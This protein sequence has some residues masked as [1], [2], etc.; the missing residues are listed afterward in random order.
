MRR[1]WEKRVDKR[2]QGRE[3]KEGV[4]LRKK[5]DLEVC[6]VW[7]IR[8]VSLRY[9][10]STFVATCFSQGKGASCR[11][12]GKKDSATPRREQK[13]RI[14]RPPGFEPGT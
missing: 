3:D 4:A 14:E 10:N 13:I 2:E 11:Y 9:R 7:L 12:Y 5:S 6:D 1:V 8:L